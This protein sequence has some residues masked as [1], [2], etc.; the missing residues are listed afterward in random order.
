[1]L[2]MYLIRSKLSPLISLLCSKEGTCARS[3]KCSRAN[4]KLGS[5]ICSLA[6]H[7]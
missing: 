6:S 4:L 2:S 3:K 1:L 5:R 7:S